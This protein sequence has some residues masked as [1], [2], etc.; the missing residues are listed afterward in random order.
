MKEASENVDLFSE[1]ASIL[2]GSF[3]HAKQETL[4]IIRANPSLERE[5][6]FDP[7]QGVSLEEHL[8]KVKE[9]GLKVETREDRERNTIVRVTLKNNYEID[10]NEVLNFDEEKARDEMLSSLE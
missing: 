9:H 1:L 2:G 5:Y 6:Y 10:I 4:D 7:T 8:A 3:K